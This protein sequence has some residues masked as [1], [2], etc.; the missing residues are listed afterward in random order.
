MTSSCSKFHITGCLLATCTVTDR[1]Y[2]QLLHNC[3]NCLD[4]LHAP[5][6]CVVMVSAHPLLPPSISCTKYST[7]AMKAFAT[8]HE[9]ND[10]IATETALAQSTEHCHYAL[11]NLACLSVYNHIA[12]SPWTLPQRAG[13]S[14][15]LCFYTTV[16]KYSSH[17]TWCT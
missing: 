17:C 9:W 15:R 12:W 16:R 7:V 11:T 6:K 4:K 13:G 10:P 3:K 1:C 14:G 5:N 2:Q 8:S